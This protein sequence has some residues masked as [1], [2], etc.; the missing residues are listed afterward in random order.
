MLS[1]AGQSMMPNGVAI[2]TFRPS[3]HVTFKTGQRLECNGQR[4]VFRHSGIIHIEDARSWSGKVAFREQ[5]V[6]KEQLHKRWK[7]LAEKIRVALPQV[8]AQLAWH[9]WFKSGPLCTATTAKTIMSLAGHP[10]PHSDSA[11][12]LM[13]MFGLGPG[14]TPSGDDFVIGYLAACYS[15]GG[16][17]AQVKIQEIDQRIQSSLQFLTTRISCHYLTKALCGEFV[18]SLVSLLSSFINSNEYKYIN[19]ISQVISKHGHSSGLDCCIGVLVGS[20]H[21]C[22]VEIDELKE[23]LPGQIVKYDS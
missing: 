20:A 8:L 2:N 12:L 18:E 7:L 19:D 16:Q 9:P 3:E 6:S 14:L 21:H 11:N 22:E 13:H 1:D 17:H 5:N 15:F 10:A 4:I 23:F